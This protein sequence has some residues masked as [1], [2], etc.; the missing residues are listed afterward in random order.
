MKSRIWIVCVAA[1]GLSLSGQAR[2][3]SQTY[4]GF[5]VGLRSGAPEP[6]A[7]VWRSEPSIV[8]VGNVAIVDRDACHDDVF[9]CDRAWWRMSDGW[10][11]RSSSWRGPWTAVDVRRVPRSVLDLPGPR[12]KHH[13]LGGPP[14]QV[15]KMRHEAREAWREDRREDRREE[16]RAERREER[17]DHGR[18]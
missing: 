3:E 12:W 9:R 11:Y 17:H 8:W 16:R 4:L 2:A 18:D 10:W 5:T 7:I 1:L 14:G 13:P 15:R 6:R